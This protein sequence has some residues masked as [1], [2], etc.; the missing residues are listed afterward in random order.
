MNG[1]YQIPNKTVYQH[2]KKKKVLA[3]TNCQ[4][5]NILNI[6]AKHPTLSKEYDFD[7]AEV[8]STYM[9]INESSEFDLDKLKDVDLFIYQPIKN[10]GKYDTENILKHISPNTICCS[11][12]YLYNY[13]FWECLVFSDGDYAI[14]TN[15]SN[16]TVINHEPVTALR[17]NGMSLEEINSKIYSKDFDWKFKERFEKTMAILRDKE[18]LCNIKVSDFINENHKHHLLFHTQNHPTLFLLQ[19]VANQIIQYVG[20]DSTLLPDINQ[21]PIP[22]YA[23]WLGLNTPDIKMGWF[24]WKYYGFT[25]MQEPDESCMDLI[26]K[27][28]EQIYNHKYVNS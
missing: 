25:F 19:H 9:L 11:F 23:I 16:Y 8:V 17:D 1:R 20:H 10:R 14:E 12:P 5:R 28:V 7:N 18:Q 6:L 21:L 27:N 22:N 13:A 3:Y 15:T 26:L 24:A 2:T 4:G